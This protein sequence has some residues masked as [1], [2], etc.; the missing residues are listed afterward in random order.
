MHARYAYRWPIECLNRPPDAL[1]M[2]VPSSFDEIDK[3]F[4]GSLGIHADP[5][6]GDRLAGHFAASAAFAGARVARR[7]LD[8]AALA[9]SRAREDLAVVWLARGPGA[10]FLANLSAAASATALLIVAD[11]EHLP[12]LRARARHGVAA[13]LRPEDASAGALEAT[14]QSL[15]AASLRQ[16]RLARDLVR[17][18]GEAARLRAALEA[19]DTAL[20]FSVEALQDIAGGLAEGATTRRTAR[21]IAK[22]ADAA[23]ELRVSR[24]QFAE[25]Y[26]RSLAGALPPRPA[27]LN[28]LASEVAREPGNEGICAITGDEPVHLSADAA[29]VATILRDIARK[30]NDVREKGDRLDFLACDAG[31]SARLSAVFRWAGPTQGLVAKAG[32][33]AEIE[34]D[35]G[36]LAEACQ[37]RVASRAPAED[38]SRLSV[39]TLVFAKVRVAPFFAASN[40]AAPARVIPAAAIR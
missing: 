4:A 30:W 38:E 37:A 6:T 11:A 40:P 17:A 36:R 35:I 9:L 8:P 22:A 5:A 31:E 14:L 10:I 23:A 34:R 29:D 2:L 25:A 20:G 18:N 21:A 32:V 16:G 28:A 33:A 7:E 39:V 12:I 1:S 13:F 19:A 3:P 27:D 15:R 26:L 24:G